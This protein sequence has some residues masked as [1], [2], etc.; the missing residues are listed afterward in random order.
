MKHHLSTWSL[1]VLHGIYECTMMST[2]LAIEGGRFSSASLIVSSAS[3]PR[4][5]LSAV[6]QSEKTPTAPP[7]Q[8]SRFQ[9]I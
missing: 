9:T 4:P 3:V 1:N 5:P 8:G 6:C 2:I 7:S